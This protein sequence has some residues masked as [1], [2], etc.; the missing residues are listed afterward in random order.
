MQPSAGRQRCYEISPEE[1]DLGVSVDER[2]HVTQQ[3]ALVAQK[4]N[5]I[6]D[7]T[8]RSVTRRPREVRNRLLMGCGCPIPT[9]IQGQAEWGFEQPEIN[10]LFFVGELG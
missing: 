6:L 3:C 10:P 2:L 5:C 4:V 9:G 1:K 8:K 7:C